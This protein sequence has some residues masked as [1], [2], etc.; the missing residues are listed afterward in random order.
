MKN[1]LGSNLT[2]TLFGESH[3]E[4][5]GAVIDGISPGIKVDRNDIDRMLTLR[6]P[7]G[8]I[9]TQRKEQDE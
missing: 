8:L 2:L 1:I 4:A 7:A 9:S 6:R 5:I 3:G